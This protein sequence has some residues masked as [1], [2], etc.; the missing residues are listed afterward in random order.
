MSKRGDSIIVRPIK[1]AFGDATREGT[2][3][4]VE[5]S[6]R[7][8][9]QRALKTTLRCLGLTVVCACIPGAHF[10]LVPLSLLLA[11]L[12]ISLSWRVTSEIVSAT[13]VCPKCDN[14]LPVLTARERYPL[15][16]NCPSCHRAISIRCDG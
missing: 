14:A 7:S 10:V 11:P 13:V 2:L 12:F 16:E 1:A 15:I 8:R 9:V 5:Y 4:V 3:E 6:K